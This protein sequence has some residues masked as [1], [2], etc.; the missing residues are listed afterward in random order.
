MLAAVLGFTRLVLA[1]VLGWP[2]FARL[3]LAAVL[4]WPLFWDLSRWCLCNLFW[5]WGFCVVVVFVIC[6]GLGGFVLLSSLFAWWLV[7]L[8]C[9]SGGL[10]GRCLRS[11][12]F[13][14][15]TLPK[16]KKH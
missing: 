12:S 8:V 16:K 10:T 14:W 3:V 11:V 4:G 2:L 5:A 9:S 1:A 7:L 13:M 15:E 6:F